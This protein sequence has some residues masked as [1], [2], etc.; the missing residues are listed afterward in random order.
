MIQD[1]I[2]FA[3]GVRPH[4]YSLQKIQNQKKKT[5]IQNQLGLKRNIPILGSP[6]LDGA[7]PGKARQEWWQP[8][9]HHHSTCLPESHTPT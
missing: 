5:K 2:Q 6:H 3:P 7:W 1:P 9:Q 4:P 8:D